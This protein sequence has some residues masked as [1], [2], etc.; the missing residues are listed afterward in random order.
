MSEEQRHPPR[1]DARQKSRSIMTRIISY[2]HQ[3]LDRLLSK[4]TVTPSDTLGALSPKLRRRRSLEVDVEVPPARPNK[5]HSRPVNSSS[6]RRSED[7]TT[8]SY[9]RKRGREE[10]EYE[11]YRSHHTSSHSQS[12]ARGVSSHGLKRV[13][14]DA[15]ADAYHVP[16]SRQGEDQANHQ[17]FQEDHHQDR[18]RRQKSPSR[19][20]HPNRPVSRPAMVN[21]GR[22]DKDKGKGRERERVPP[23]HADGRSTLSM[24]QLSTSAKPR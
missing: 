23:G 20:I 19:G 10:E 14:M 18:G 1:R 7:Y 24:K 3:G 17:T 9:S 11:E 2:L 6:I 8:S 4:S 16:R 12:Q 5:R 22:E 15:A 21:T 13:R